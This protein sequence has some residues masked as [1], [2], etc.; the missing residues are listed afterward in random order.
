MSAPCGTCQ[1]KADFCLFGMLVTDAES[2]QLG[3]NILIIVAVIIIPQTQGQILAG[4]LRG[5][6]DNRFIAIYS[7]FI[8]AILRS[9]LAFFFA[10]G[11]HMGLYGMWVA[12]L[13]D[14]ILKMVLTEYRIRKGVW[15]RRSI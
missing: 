15:L 14:E 7:L 1:R 9:A 6:G 12:L 3:A 11:L 2:M 4:A 13:I 8:S 5:T 10:F